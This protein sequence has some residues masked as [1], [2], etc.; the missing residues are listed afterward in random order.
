VY[1]KSIHLLPPYLVQHLQSFGQIIVRRQLERQQFHIRV[2]GFQQGLLAGDPAFQ[3]MSQPLPFQ[4]MRGTV[5]VPSGM[6]TLWRGPLA[7]LPVCV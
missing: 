4:S 7:V 3:R 2:M 5:S 1:Q 6:I